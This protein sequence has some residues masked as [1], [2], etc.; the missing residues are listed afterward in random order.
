MRPRDEITWDQSHLATLIPGFPGITTYVLRTYY[1]SRFYI[2]CTVLTS[3]EYLSLPS[4][5]G[6]SNSKISWDWSRETWSHE[7][8]WEF[9]SREVILEKIPVS[10]KLMR[11]DWDPTLSI[12]DIVGIA[13]DTLSTLGHSSPIIPPHRS[14]GSMGHWEVMSI[15]RLSL[16]GWI[17]DSVT[18]DTFSTVPADLT[19]FS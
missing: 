12:I 15:I 17:V 18:I 3:A 5:I 7:V 16:H 4:Y 2:V 9:S 19:Y 6:T 1:L 8:S 14:V 13:V 10:L 11:W